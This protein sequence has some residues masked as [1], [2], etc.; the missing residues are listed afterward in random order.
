MCSKNSTPQTSDGQEFNMKS[1]EEIAMA[2]AN[3]TVGE[4]TEAQVRDLVGAPSYEESLICD[5]GEPLAECKDSYVHMT[6]GY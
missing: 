2:I 4:L 1:F 5:C 6:S 3:K